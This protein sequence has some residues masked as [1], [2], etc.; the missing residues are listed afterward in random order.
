MT[1]TLDFLSD[2]LHKTDADPLL[3][4]Q[5][6]SLSFLLRNTFGFDTLTVN[7][8][9]EE[10]QNGGFVRSAKTLAIE[11]LNNMGIRFSLSTLFNLRIIKLFVTRLNRVARKLDA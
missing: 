5:S 11:N 1:V 8:C 10:M 6:E 4:M 2:G 3:K 7:G 9:F